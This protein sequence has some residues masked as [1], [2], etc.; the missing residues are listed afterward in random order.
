[1]REQRVHRQRPSDKMPPHRL[2][3]SD[4]EAK[5]FE[6]QHRQV[7]GGSRRSDRS[8][9]LTSASSGAGPVSLADSQHDLLRRLAMAGGFAWDGRDMDAAQ[10]LALAE[11]LHWVEAVIGLLRQRRAVRV[12][13]R[14]DI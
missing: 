5:Q 2:Q 13:V 4:E 10:A 12:E 6:V 9:L 3:L 1:M 14:R 8:V 7:A 11:C